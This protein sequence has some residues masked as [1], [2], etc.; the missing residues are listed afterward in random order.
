M[1]Q[2]MTPDPECATI[3]TPI[4]DAL[5]KMHEGRFLHL[6][7]IDRGNSIHKTQTMKQLTHTHTHTRR[8]TLAPL[9]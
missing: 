9:L 1:F 3:D 8:E 6:P 2:V 7:V 5:H 4:V